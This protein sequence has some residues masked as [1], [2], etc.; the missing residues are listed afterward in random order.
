MRN[1]STCIRKLIQGSALIVLRPEYASKR[2]I[3]KWTS[4]KL[5][6][7]TFPTY[8]MIGPTAKLYYLSRLAVTFISSYSLVVKLLLLFLYKGLPRSLNTASAVITN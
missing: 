2:N 7:V 8:D 3:Y 6:Y 1:L 4:G 5:R